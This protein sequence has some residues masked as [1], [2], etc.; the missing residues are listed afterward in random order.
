MLP[1]QHPHS[2]SIPISLIQPAEAG[3]T[4][5]F[6]PIIYSTKPSYLGYIQFVCCSYNA[7]DDNG[8]MSLVGHRRMP[9]NSTCPPAD[10]WDIPDTSISR[11][12]LHV[13]LTLIAARALINTLL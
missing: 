6:A 8:P 9:G 11:T 1:L 5:G 10:H 12:N 2:I 4:I 7:T 13:D 3:C